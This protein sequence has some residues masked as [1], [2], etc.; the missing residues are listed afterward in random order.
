MAVSRQGGQGVETL[1]ENSVVD[2]LGSSGI[3]RVG[4]SRRLVE[5]IIDAADQKLEMFARVL[6]AKLKLLLVVG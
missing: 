1:Q 4:A 5:C 2:G 3:E 6:D